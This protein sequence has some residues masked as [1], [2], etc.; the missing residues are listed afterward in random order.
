MPF[1][2]DIQFNAD[3]HVDP[4]SLDRISKGIQAHSAAL[5]FKFLQN[6]LFLPHIA[7]VQ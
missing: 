6:T 7:V 3:G 1:D 2:R 4:N 5:G